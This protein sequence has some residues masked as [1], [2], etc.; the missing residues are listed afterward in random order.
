MAKYER[1]RSPTW[2]HVS[3]LSGARAVRTSAA[4]LRSTANFRLYKLPFGMN[5]VL[6]VVNYMVSGCTRNMFS[7]TLIL[8]D[9]LLDK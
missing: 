7:A 5:F 9:A 4:S 3:A 1:V 6:S 2:G 8:L